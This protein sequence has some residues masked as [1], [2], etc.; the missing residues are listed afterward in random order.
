LVQVWQKPLIPQNANYFGGET[1]WFSYTIDRA[2]SHQQTSVQGRI[3]K[4]VQ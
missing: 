3:R 4:G 1:T 2:Y